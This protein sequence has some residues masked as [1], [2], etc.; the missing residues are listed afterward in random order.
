M[1]AATPPAG[2][3]PRVGRYRPH[4]QSG[5]PR[6][7]RLRYTDQEYATVERAAHVAGLTS[8]GYVAEA[9]LA[10]AAGGEPTTSAPWRD[11]L[12]E[13]MQ[14]RAQVR[15]IGLNINQAARALNVA[16]EPPVWLEY[17]LALTERAVTGLDEAATAVADCARGPRSP[18][19]SHRPP[20]QAGQP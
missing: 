14:A 1:N 12:T 20:T 9:A 18:T 16:G 10:A 19:A 3:G 2:P 17:A 8:T 4:A 7:V 15:R 6:Q 13:L 11:A 5:R